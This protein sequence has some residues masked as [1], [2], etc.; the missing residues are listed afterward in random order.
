VLAV[1]LCCV[2]CFAG[3][4][5]CWLCAQAP[6]IEYLNSNVTMLKWMIAEGARRTSHR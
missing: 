1:L 6:V 3:C 2:C 4:A 5:A